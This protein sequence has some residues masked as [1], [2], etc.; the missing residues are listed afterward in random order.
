[1]L[2]IERPPQVGNLARQM[3]CGVGL[4]GLLLVSVVGL[5]LVVSSGTRSAYARERT[6]GNTESGIAAALVYTSPTDTVPPGRGPHPPAPGSIRVSS[7]YTTGGILFDG[8]LAFDDNPNTGWISDPAQRPEGQWIE[9]DV[10]PNAQLDE[11]WLSVYVS[12][13]RYSRPQTSTLTTANGATQVWA[14][15]DTS[16]LQPHKLVTPVTGRVRLTIDTVWRSNRQP[17]GIAD[18]TLFMSNIHAA[19]PTPPPTPDT[20][21]TPLPIAATAPTPAPAPAP[22]GGTSPDPWRWWLVGVMV[23]LAGFFLLRGLRRQ[24][25]R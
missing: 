25:G 8:A 1:M 9:W 11:V 7:A 23:L 21:P 10:L 13:M 3:R 12:A 16:Q 14:W 18:L 22:A 24:R 17:V 15:D 2:R 20:L 6:S 19:A 4:A 5:T